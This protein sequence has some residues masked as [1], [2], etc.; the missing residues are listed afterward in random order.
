MFRR[1]EMQVVLKRTV[2]HAKNGYLVRSP[3]LRLTAYGSSVELASLNME[4]L[5]LQFLRPFERS[6]SLADEL[7]AA[8]L[9]TQPE[10]D[11]LAVT[12]V[13]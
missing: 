5:A 4:R 10:A 8:R 12:L 6:G 2:N 9:N 13:D 1:A 3:E 11:D 7:A